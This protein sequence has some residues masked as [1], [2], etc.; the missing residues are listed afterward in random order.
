V[1]VDADTAR[2]VG[3]EDNP[4]G[5]HDDR[6][7]KRRRVPRLGWL[8]V[9]AVTAI[10]VLGGLT[11]WYT[12]QTVQSRRDDATR[13]LF[14]E[15]GKQSAIN[16]TTIHWK[17]A[18]ADV[19]RILDGATGT[20]YDDFSTRAKPFIDVVKQA[21]S[22]SVGTVSEAGLESVDADQAQVL[23]TMAVKTSNDGVPQPDTRLW[24]M[25]LAVQKMGD[26]AK[27]SNVEFVP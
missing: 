18:D 7:R 21:K 8:A 27:V 15:T 25:R 12:W 16:L 19:K 17:Q 6:A 20:F 23:V 14:V 5:G 4:D 24:R 9:A 2:T 13:A 1:A 11:G 3:D 10:A 26:T 22:A